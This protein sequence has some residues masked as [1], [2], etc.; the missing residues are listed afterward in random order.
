M[1]KKNTGIKAAIQNSPRH[2]EAPHP[3]DKPYNSRCLISGCNT[4]VYYDGAT[5][6]SLCLLHLQELELGPYF[7]HDTDR[8]DDYDS[9]P[10]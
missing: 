2:R 3:W 5:Y 6:F 1:I 4:P 9:N 7:K 10:F 8:T